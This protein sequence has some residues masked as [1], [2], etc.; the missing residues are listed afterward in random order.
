LG[1]TVAL[2]GVTAREASTAAVTV[3]VVLPLTPP[4]VAV[5]TDEPVFTE[6]ARPALPPAFEMVAVA[7]VP[8]VHVTAVVKV[9]IVASVYVPVAV[10]CRVSPFAIDGLAG[11]T[12][13]DTSVAAVTVNVVLPLTPPSVAVMTDDPVFT[14]DASPALPP[15]FEMVA[16]PV[17]PDVQV[18]AVVRVCVVMS[19]YVPVAVNW[20]VRPFAIDGAAGVTAIETNVAAVTVSVVLPLTPPKVAVITLLPVFTEDASPSL[21]PAFEIVAVAV[22]ADVHVTAVVRFCV[23]V[24]V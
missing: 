18:T 22:V 11:V 6:E 12:A 23:V 14:D 2:A 21:P 5:M 3:N 20:R 19:V 24:S 7:V 15:A 13:M 17:V 16:V 10:N 4:S 9:C 8:D 1:S